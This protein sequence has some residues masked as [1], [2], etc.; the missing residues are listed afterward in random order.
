MAWKSLGLEPC[1]N[2]LRLNL[3]HVDLDW[4]VI[5]DDLLDFLR[6]WRTEVG[7]VAATEREEEEDEDHDCSLDPFRPMI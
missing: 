2:C 6:D 1:N 7:F 4:A 3:P 5:V